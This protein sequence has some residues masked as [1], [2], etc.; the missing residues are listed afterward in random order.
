[1][2]R[3]KRT[4]RVSSLIAREISLIIDRDLRDDRVAMTTVTG[5]EVSKDL[6]FGKVFVSVL[7]DDAAVQSTLEILNSASSFI[8]SLLGERA[9]LRF[10]PELTFHY[11]SSTVDGMRMDRILESLH[12]ESD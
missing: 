12:K 6:K 10:I 9:T 4:D 1:M 3:F 7:G 8:K 2:K 5:V 11:D